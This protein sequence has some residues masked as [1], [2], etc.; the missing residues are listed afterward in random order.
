MPLP[1]RQKKILQK[2][3]LMNILS[4]FLCKFQGFRSYISVFNPFWVYIC[5]CCEKMLYFWSFP[6]RCSVWS[7][8]L[9]E[10]TCLFSFLRSCIKSFR[11]IS[12]Y[13]HRGATLLQR[14]LTFVQHTQILQGARKTPLN[15]YQI[16]ISKFAS[17]YIYHSCMYVA[18]HPST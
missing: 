8:P 17:I 7:T 16:F 18:I 11:V 15:I 14:R 6:C 2:E 1:L 3:T 10:E 13:G 12:L 9:T 4:I 5:I